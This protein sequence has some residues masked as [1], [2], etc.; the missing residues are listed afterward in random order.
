MTAP[1]RDQD[2]LL[3]HDMGQDEPAVH[4]GGPLDINMHTEQ[5]E[6]LPEALGSAPVPDSS[7]VNET[8]QVAKCT[9]PSPEP[10]PAPAPIP[11]ADPVQEEASASPAPTPEPE[12]AAQSSEPTPAQA[13]EP[14]E[15]KP[16]AASEPEQNGLPSQ[17]QPARK[18]KTSKSK[19]PSLKMQAAVDEPAQTNEEEELPVPKAAYN[20][21]PDQL[22]ASFNPFTS[23]GSKIQNSPPP[24]GSNSAP[25][26]EPDG[27][28]FPVSETSSAAPADTAESSSEAKPVMLE[29]SLDEGTV[30]KPPPRKL[31]GKK[32][33]SKLAAKKQR[34]K[35]SEAPC[36]PAPEP[37]VSEPV[38]EPV[39]E[40]VSES[41][42]EPASDPLP[43]TSLPVSDSSA[44]VNLDDVPIP[45]SGAYNFD[46]SQWDDPNFNPFGSNNKMSSSPVLPRGSYN[47]DPDNFDDSVDPFKPS[48]GLSTEDSSSSTAQP[49]KKAKD[50]GKQKAGQLPGEKKAR[51][52]P[53]KGKERTAT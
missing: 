50:G 45:K 13:P 24:C 11:V 3:S 28:S 51:P 2:I 46:P 52:I 29:F 41:V 25:R 30:S 19:P 27:C 53:K 12:S 6:D 21:D 48:R 42:S 18:T 16:T 32:T 49:E 35:G 1:V 47:F 9:P 20:F 17:T 10:P 8:P 26:L 23:G 31:G 22:D 38:S 5:E 44:P 33:I 39:P 15:E 40:P 7:S 36:K 14:P 4:M 37:A 34:P 43:E